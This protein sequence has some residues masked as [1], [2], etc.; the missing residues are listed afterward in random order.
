MCLLLTLEAVNFSLI[1][2]GS[3]LARKWKLRECVSVHKLLGTTLDDH[4][5]A[6]SKFNSFSSLCLSPPEYDS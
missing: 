6:A 4:A 5:A 2:N 1:S 3:G